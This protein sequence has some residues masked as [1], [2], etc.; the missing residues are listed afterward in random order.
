MPVEP[1]PR[2]TAPAGANRPG[3]VA[4]HPRWRRR[5]VRWGLIA[6]SDFLDL[7]GDIL[8]GHA[9]R[10][11]VRVVLGR[12]RRRAVFILKREHRVPWRE[13]LRNAIAGFGWCSKSIRE[14]RILRDLRRAGI[15][16]PR[17][18]AFGE[19]GTG[20]AFLLIRA[21]PGAVDL[22]RFLADQGS[23]V[24]NRELARRVGRL[25]ARIHAAGFDC[26]DLS[27]KHVLVRRRNLAPLLIDWQ[28]TRRSGRVP[29]TV[30]VRELA[31]L[32][33]TLADELASPR[34]RLAAL[35]TYLRAALGS[36]PTLRPWVDL[37]LQRSERLLRRRTV[38]DQRRRLIAGSSQRLRWLDGERLVVS[39]S[40]WR[41]HRRG[42]PQWLTVAAMTRVREKKE[43]VQTWLGGKVILQQFPPAGPLRRWW[44]RLRGRHTIAAGPRLAG[45]LFRRQRCGEAAPRPLAFGQQ[46]NG[47]SFI[48]F[49][50][51]DHR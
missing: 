34:E 9:N 45:H 7:P 2:M 33:A 18:V 28:R 38:Q 16:A 21:T 37:I 36:R 4:A 31:C 50:P 23:P 27:S 13:R 44:D 43:F 51:A 17:C 8:S 19:D 11:V 29:W 42:V 5:F 10:Q 35:G 24:V 12:G 26:P 25:L 41:A 3:W 20:R 1:L 6:A 40:V 22:R 32:H 47:G 49:R 30:R 46:P 14:A 15:P 39:R 48:V